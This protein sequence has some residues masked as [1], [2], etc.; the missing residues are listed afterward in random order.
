MQ[1]PLPLPFLIS[2]VA[3]LLFW[4]SDVMDDIVWRSG[5][6]GEAKFKGRSKLTKADQEQ[7]R[8][9]GWPGTSLRL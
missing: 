2:F 8:S 1:V 3:H 5:T 9:F 6:K 4:V 7:R